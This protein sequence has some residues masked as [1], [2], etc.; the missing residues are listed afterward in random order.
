MSYIQSVKNSIKDIVRPGSLVMVE[1]SVYVGATREY[2]SDFLERGIYVGF[3]PERV[4]PGRTEP[5][6][7]AIPK[8]ISGLNI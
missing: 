3:S 6:M 8:V 2:F 1:S 5:P 7:Q 4:D